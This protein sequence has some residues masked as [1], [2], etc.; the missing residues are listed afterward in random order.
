MNHAHKAIV[1]RATRE[2]LLPMELAEELMGHDLLEL[3]LIQMKK[4][5]VAF[6]NMSE[7]QQDCAIAEMQDGLKA[8]IKTAVSIVGAQA[9]KTVRMSLKGCAVGKKLKV[10]GEIS[11]DEEWKHEL[12]DA[13]TD[14]ADVLVILNERD[15]LQG[16]DAHHGEK[17]QK[18]L[19]LETSDDAEKPAKAPRKAK[20]EP[21]AKPESKTVVIDAE[22]LDKAREFVVTNKNASIAGLQNRLSIGFNKANALLEALAAEG[23]VEFVGSDIDGQWEMVSKKVAALSVE[24]IE[25]AELAYVPSRESR[26]EI[27]EL[28]ESLMQKIREKTVR[29]GEVYASGLIVSFDMPEDLANT[30]IERLE[31]EGFISAEDDM[32]L[33]TIIGKAA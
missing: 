18:A 8:A 11:A 17:Q 1:Q 20:A 4:H 27:V 30:A 12:L 25:G 29:D 7:I 2:G 26:L 19:P 14:Q 10:T 16:M 24:E 5:A 22:T 3:M 31:L 15:F 23:V 21:K 32:G 28:T 9:T 33:R 6:K 13:A